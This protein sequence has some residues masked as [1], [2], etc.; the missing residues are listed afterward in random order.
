MPDERRSLVVPMFV[1]KITLIRF[2]LFGRQH[3]ETATVLVALFRL[4]APSFHRSFT[5]D[6]ADHKSH[7]WACVLCVEREAADGE[8]QCRWVRGS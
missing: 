5:L 2:A 4:S 1:R 8:F 7:D 3:Q 6:V